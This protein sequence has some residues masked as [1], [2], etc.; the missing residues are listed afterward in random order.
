MDQFNEAVFLSKSTAIFSTHEPKYIFA[1]LQDALTSMETEAKRDEKKW[2]MTF[3]AVKA[4]SDEEIKEKIP[5]EGCRVTVKLLKVD[6]DRVCIEF[7][8][9]MGNSWFFFDTVKQLKDRL[10]DLNDSAL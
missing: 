4:Q 5:S 8:R 3:E 10:K 2:K 6:E 7:N 9:T 1:K